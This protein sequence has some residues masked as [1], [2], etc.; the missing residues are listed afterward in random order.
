L[1]IAED[2]GWKANFNFVCCR[3]CQFIWVDPLPDEDFLREFYL[4]YYG[5]SRYTAKS[6]KKIKRSLRRLL[7]LRR[8]VSGDQ[9]ID[10]GCNAGFAVEA[11]RRAG[12]SATGID[13]DSDT[14]EYATQQFPGAEFHATDISAFAAN[15]QQFD[16]AY[17]SEVLEHVREVRPFAQSLAALIRPG[18]L[19]FLTTPDAGHWRVPRTFI[20][21]PEV[22]PP[23][24]VC[25]FSKPNILQLF[26]DVGLKVERFSMNVKPGMKVLARKASS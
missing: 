23:E 21:W 18:G 12:F 11:A 8:L 24:H 7:R 26:G 19:L 6:D 9:F 10:I 17:C 14:I 16:L 5:T 2:L 25:W 1:D 22:K 3:Q 15:G 13:I 4:H 20:E